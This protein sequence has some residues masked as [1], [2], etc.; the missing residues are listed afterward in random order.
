MAYV[1]TTIPG[2]GNAAAHGRNGHKNLFWR[3]RQIATGRAWLAQSAYSGTGNG[4][5][6]ETDSAVAA[7]TET[8]TLTC[9]DATTPGAEVWSVS[10]SVSGA[11]ANATTGVAYDNGIIKF[12]IT[13]GGTN[14]AVSD[15]FTLAAT[16]SP[17]PS[18]QRWT[19]NAEDY[20]TADWTMLLQ[21]PNISGFS[22]VFCGF[23]TRQDVPSDYYNIVLQGAIGYVASN[24]WA[25]Q[26]NPKLSTVPLWQFDIPCGIS[27]T[28]LKIAFWVNVE[29]NTDAGYTGLYLPNM[30]PNEYDFPMLV[31]GSIDGESTTRYSDTSRVLGMLSNGGR[32]RI[33]FID[34][35]WKTV[36]PWPWFADNTSSDLT[37]GN[38]TT[39]PTQDAT[40]ADQRQLLPIHLMDAGNG[41][42]G[43]LQDVFFISGFALAV[44]DV[45][46]DGGGNTFKVVRNIHRTGVRDYIAFRRA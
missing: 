32:Q 31:S 18:A 29:G 16:A 5:I 26:P 21:G 6:V 4:V 40:P 20:S 25:S 14:F 17:L 10:G 12:Q 30:T 35:T 45:I 27:V 7:P 41:L 2:V 44:G 9:T 8:W 11:Q 37:L 38:N 1:E 36:E 39:E 43:T 22:D 42:Y 3:I 46:D 24:P 34:G 19:L 33:Y 23:K 15:Q 13:A 28:D